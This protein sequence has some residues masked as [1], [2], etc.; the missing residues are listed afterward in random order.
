MSAAPR[1]TVAG[2][3]A[4]GLCTALALADA[5]CRVTV[6]DPSP[7][8]GR[9]SWVAAG[10]LAPAFET[11]LDRDG[12]QNLPLL[13]AA[14]DLWPSLAARI[15]L[16][17][18]R[19]G[20]LAV[21]AEAWMEPVADDLEAIGLPIARIGR[22]ELDRL[23]VGLSESFR[24]GLISR[25]DWR[26][27]AVAAM[28]ALRG[29]AQAAGVVFEAVAVQG[30]GD[31]DHLVLA[32]GAAQGPAPE[33]ADLVPIKGHILRL[34]GVQAG[35]VTVRGEGGYVSP[36]NGGLT[37][38]ATMEVGV[39]D[40]VVDPARGPGLLAA[41]AAL[42]PGLA[43]RTFT[44]LAG[45]RAATRDGLPMV[46]ASTEPG[47]LIAVGGRRNGWLLAPLVASLIVAQVT[48]ADPGPWAAALDPGRFRRAP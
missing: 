38:G 4:L 1:V 29:A 44:L 19:D 28:A 37:I 7:E 41:G 39:A 22:A 30:R 14:R 11:V 8:G 46:G 12:P 31:A 15:D 34:A 48:G 5:G 40:P 21:G 25:A 33:L 26:L 32:T 23:A 45:V 42:F 35:A 3:G 47:I 43:E 27:D 10:M 6:R 24:H 9:A 20:A 17:L 18:A 36:I 16:D 13:L 2:A